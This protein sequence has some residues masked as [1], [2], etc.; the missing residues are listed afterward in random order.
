VGD[1]RADEAWLAEVGWRAT[2][3]NGRANLP[4]LDFYAPGEVAVGLLE[5]LQEAAAHGFERVGPRR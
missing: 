4:G 3:A 1:T 5:I 2:P